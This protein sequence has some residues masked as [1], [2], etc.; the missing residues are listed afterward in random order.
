MSPLPK[1][2]RR[3]SDSNVEQS[4]RYEQGKIGEDGGLELA[5]PDTYSKMDV[6]LKTSSKKVLADV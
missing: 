4:S 1:I 3:D 6:M 5:M 2:N